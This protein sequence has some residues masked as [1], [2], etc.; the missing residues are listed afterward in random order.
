M[1]N[2]NDRFNENAPGAWYVDTNCIGCGQCDDALP[3]VF[4]RSDEGDHN[5]VQRQPETAEEL[6]RAEEARESC[7]VDAIG[8]DG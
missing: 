1:A 4:K 5:Y 6:T 3:S 2:P 8:R 7:P